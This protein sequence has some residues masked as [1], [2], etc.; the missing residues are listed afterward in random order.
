M[1]LISTYI[2]D[3]FLDRVLNIYCCDFF[4]F[5]FPHMWQKRLGS[6]FMATFSLRTILVPYFTFVIL[7]VFCFVSFWF[8]FDFV[9]GGGGG[10]GGSDGGHFLAFSDLCLKFYFSVFFFSIL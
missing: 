10:G 5:Y 9:S 8:G 6:S 2:W 7:A 3:A 1:S 4:S